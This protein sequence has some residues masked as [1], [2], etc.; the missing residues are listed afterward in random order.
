MKNQYT[1]LAYGIFIGIALTL[2]VGLLVF[3]Q[4]DAGP[5]TP[6]F[7]FRIIIPP[8]HVDTIKAAPAAK[9][10]SEI[11]RE[12]LHKIDSLYG[13]SIKDAVQGGRI[14]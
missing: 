9:S 3:A 8:V 10:D 14:R 5:T 7:G 11:N 6:E 4:I 13:D 2:I 1:A 12:F